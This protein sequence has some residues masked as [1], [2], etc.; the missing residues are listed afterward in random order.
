[1]TNI[2]FKS[3]VIIG[4][5]LIGSS[6]ARV[7]IEKNIASVITPIGMDHK[8]FLKKSIEKAG[9]CFLHAPLFH[10][11]MK[12]VAPVR[13]ELRLKTFFNMLGPMVNPSMPKKQMVGVYN[14][15]LAR[16]YN[17][18][19]QNTDIEYNI[20]HALDGYDEISLTGNTKVYS[21]SNEFILESKDFKLDD[22]NAD[23][24]KG[25]Q[26]VESSSK[27]FMNVLDGRGSIEQENV[28][29][30]NA[31]MA[32]SLSKKVTIIEAFE[33]AKESIKSKAALKCFEKLTELM[34]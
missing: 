11:A 33:I 32:I 28:V 7:L 15:E 29:C 27:I 10:P 19:Y 31:S 3:V 16:I 34:K 13:K 1:M 8:D 9:I 21:R 18:L 5:G 22:I 12:N 14:L 2:N 24:I 25:G 30:A 26:D 4:V 6:I 17:Y 20:I 23:S